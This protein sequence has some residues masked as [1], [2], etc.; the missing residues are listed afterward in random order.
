MTQTMPLIPLYY[1]SVVITVENS[2]VLF[3]PL[4]KKKIVTEFSGC[5]VGIH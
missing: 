1:Y 3:S 2:G 4:K 5:R